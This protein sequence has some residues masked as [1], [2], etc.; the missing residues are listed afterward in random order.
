MSVFLCS[1]RGPLS[2]LTVFH[3]NARIASFL[4]LRDDLAVPNGSSLAFQ[5]AVSVFSTALAALG[6]EIWQVKNWDEMMRYTFTG[7][8]HNVPRLYYSSVQTT[9]RNFPT[10]ICQIAVE[11]AFVWGWLLC[12]LFIFKWRPI[13]SWVLWAFINL[14][15]VTSCCCFFIPPVYG[16]VFK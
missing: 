15:P 4:Q 12:N 13:L 11:S 14:H 9:Q 6:N 8:I 3:S 7:H 16:L 10:I 5:T 1:V 2:F